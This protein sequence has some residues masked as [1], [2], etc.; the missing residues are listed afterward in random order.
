M[1]TSTN[2][3]NTMDRPYFA[4]IDTETNYNDKVMSIGVVI[5]DKKTY[6]TITE[7]YYI[8]TPECDDSAMFGY[9]LNE[10]NPFT[11]CSRSEAISD[12]CVLLQSHD[13]EDIFAYNAKF[14]YNHLPELTEFIW[15]DIMRIAAYKQ[16]NPNI[17]DDAECCLTGR[18]KCCYGVE[19]MMR[20]LSG[21]ERYCEKHNAVCDA[22]DELLIMKIIG[23][24]TEQY[25]NIQE[26]SAQKKRTP[27]QTKRPVWNKTEQLELCKN[28]LQS[29]LLQGNIDLICFKAQNK[30]VTIKCKRCG[31]LWDVSYYTAKDKMPRCPQCISMI[32]HKKAEYGDY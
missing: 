25:P 21:D 17:P 2:R 8:I 26:A 15:H 23:Y 12:L 13:V 16:Y 14:D 28:D 32:S 11:K 10:Y 9:A 5:A 29:Y 18:L 24:P 22:K 19:H 4:V 3:Q 20:M 1:D 31:Y 30:P 27:V 7:K 6:H